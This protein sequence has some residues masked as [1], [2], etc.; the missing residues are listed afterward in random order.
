MLLPGHLVLG[1]SHRRAGRHGGTA[2]I[3]LGIILLLIEVFVL[4]GFGVAGIAGLFLVVLGVLMA[5]V[6]HYP[7]GPVLPTWSQLERPI[8][9]LTLSMVGAFAFGAV[10]ARFLP[11]SQ[12]FSPL[13]LD[14]T[15]A[16]ADGYTASASSADLM[17]L[18]GE[19]VTPL[20]PAGAAMF[21]NRRVD[22][23]TE[24]EFIDAG[25]RIRVVETHGSRVVV[26]PVETT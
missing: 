14:T 1:P 3:I 16:R 22:V 10:L 9:V 8:Q 2:L 12:L 11:K 17:G 18:R 26:E 5:M 20:R 19:A 7:G 15:S 21:G 13:R 23:V 24:G 4:P 25:T 6:Q